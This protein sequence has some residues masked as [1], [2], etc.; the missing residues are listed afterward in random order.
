MGRINVTSSI[1]EGTLVP[2]MRCYSTTACL[3]LNISSLA[4][5][6][7]SSAN[8]NNFLLG[9]SGDN[10][11]CRLYLHRITSLVIPWTYI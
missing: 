5:C 2:N 4:S 7:C 11:S 6:F 8:A 10:A 9:L 1:F 3:L